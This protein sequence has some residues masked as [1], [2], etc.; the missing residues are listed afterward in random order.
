M[1]DSIV[2]DLKNITKKFPGVVALK[3]VNFNLAKSEVHALVGENGAGKS[4]LIK[5]LMG[6]YLKGS[7]EIIINDRLVDIK[8]P[9]DS[10]LLGIGAIYQESSLIP[11][12]SIGENIFL[13][14]IT[15]K[16]SVIFNSSNIFRRSKEI[17]K[18]LGSNLNP[19]IK[20]S[21]L[22]AAE[23]KMVEI[24]KVMSRN[25]SILIL[26]EPTA[27]LPEKETEMLF[28]LISSLK[29][30]G[31]SI[32][33]ISHYLD[34]IFRIADR[35]T[36]L[37]NGENVGTLLAKEENRVDIIQLMVGKKLEKLYPKEDISIGEDL[38]VVE[39]L[40]K[41]GSY[42][43]ISF[44]L[45]KGEILGFFGLIGS[46]HTKIIRSLYGDLMPD[47]GKIFIKGKNT[48]IISPSHAK[49]YGI[50]LVP[51]DRKREGLILEHNVIENL[52]LG[53]IGNFMV[54]GLIKKGLEKLK[55]LE[56]IKRFYIKITDLSQRV[57]NLSGGNQQ[58]VIISRLLESKA[59]ILLLEGPTVGV[60]IGAKTEIYKILEDQCK[61]G[62]GI[63]MVSE[64]IMET[65]SMSDRIIVVKGGEIV[66]EL[67]SKVTS[68]EGLLN[69]AI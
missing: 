65:L 24:A 59:F 37:R 58:K 40:T 56:W 35:V 12:M 54:F 36:I 32:I 63:I 49:R 33:Y 18:R 27:A 51:G 60:D 48:R 1:S 42:R 25:A 57:K 17:L 10:L 61:E 34:E 66:A 28:G 22:N 45:Y 19:E 9:R 13:G 46:G 41:K 6:N 47:S 16:N 62:K 15:E 38:L 26:D 30:S 44:N 23:S 69:K 14:N 20:A 43:N 4:T 2:L 67:K 21:Q 52:S 7:G 39:N 11:G 31:I 3:D 50:G 68:K 29:K 55:V 53:N 5:V 8:T 64:D